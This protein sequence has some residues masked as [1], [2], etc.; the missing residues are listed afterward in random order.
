MSIGRKE[1]TK[2]IRDRLQKE[3][4]KGDISPYLVREGLETILELIMEALKR[5]EKVKISGFGT[6]ESR[7][8]KAKKGRDFLSGSPLLLP[9][10]KKISFRISSRLSKRLNT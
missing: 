3:Y 9:P 2:R 1:L 6:F 5:E 10:R 8:R 7:L 4:S